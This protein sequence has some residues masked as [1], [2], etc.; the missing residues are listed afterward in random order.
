MV[1]ASKSSRWGGAGWWNKCGVENLNEYNYGTA[2]IS[3]KCMFWYNWGK[4]LECLKLITMAIR[5]VKTFFS[6]ENKYH[7]YLSA[8]SSLYI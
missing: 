4:K 6:N 3:P 2:K 7:K 5:P 8:I 1:L